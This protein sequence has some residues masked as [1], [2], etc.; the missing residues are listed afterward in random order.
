MNA[1]LDELQHD[2]FAECSE[3]EMRAIASIEKRDMRRLTVREKIVVGMA[4]S[5]TI[6]ALK[7][8]PQT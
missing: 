7:H 4:V 3:I 2:D 8:D 6:N 5:F 1:R